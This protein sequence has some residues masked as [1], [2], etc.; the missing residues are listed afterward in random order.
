MANSNRA[1][2]AFA[3]TNSFRDV[4]RYLLVIL[5]VHLGVILLLTD[6]GK[7]TRSEPFSVEMLSFLQGFS[8]SVGGRCISREAL[9]ESGSVV[10]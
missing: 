10:K 9:A 5:R 4:S 2:P 7:L 8:L 3:S 6:L 1:S